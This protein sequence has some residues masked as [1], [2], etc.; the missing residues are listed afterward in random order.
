[1]WFEEPGDPNDYFLHA[2]LINQ[3]AVPIAV[4]E[5]LFSEQD[6]K[7]MIIY[8]NLRSNIDYL[9]MDANLA[10]GVT[11]FVRI[12]KMVKD[13]GWDESR[14]YPHGGNLL[15]LHLCAAFNLGGTECYPGFFKPFGGFYDNTVIKNG[16][17][18]LP[19]ECG[20]GVEQKKVLYDLMVKNLL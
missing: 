4:G 7:N 13:F 20:V 1:M 9:Q 6:V 19:M 15:G 14:I 8:G 12:L 18:Q 2:S 5:N 11:G 16:Y 17:V 10:Y 3:N